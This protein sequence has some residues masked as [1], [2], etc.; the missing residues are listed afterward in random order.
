MPVAS[1]PSV[2]LTPS[3]KALA[4]TR[5]ALRDRG[6]VE[7]HEAGAD[8]LPLEENSQDFGYSLG[9][10]HH[11]PDTEGAMRDCVAKLRPGA[12]FLVY[13]YYRLENRPV[14]FRAMW[15][16]SDFARRALSRLPFGARRLG[17]ESLAALAYL[18]LARL[19]QVGQRQGFNVSNWPLSHYRDV[20]YYTM[21]TDAL[22]RFGTRLERF[23]RAEIEAMMNR[24]GLVDVRFRAGPPYWVAVGRKAASSSSASV[25]ST[26]CRM[27]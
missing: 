27:E 11:I 23:T 4:V 25:R 26:I 5:R 20:S 21:R 9:V 15:H 24:C 12:P 14:W 17:A 6:N 1:G 7:F 13:L 16:T 18:P 22:D 3:G 19:A 8:D 10:L 2:G